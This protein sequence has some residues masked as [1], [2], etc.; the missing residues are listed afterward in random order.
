MLA[1]CFVR[2]E[3]YSA[4]RHRAQITP[5]LLRAECSRYFTYRS[6][7]AELNVTHC[8]NSSYHTLMGGDSQRHHHPNGFLMT[9]VRCEFH[10]GVPGSNRPLTTN[11]SLNIFN[12]LV[13]ND[14]SVR[15]QAAPALCTLGSRYSVQAK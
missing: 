3:K 8:S 6:Y 11:I 14:L 12:R 1:V 2:T 13:M 5:R 4:G 7:R 15:Q 10:A 9:A